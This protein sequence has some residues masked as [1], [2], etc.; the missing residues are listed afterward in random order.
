MNSPIAR[1]NL[2]F[3]FEDAEYIGSQGFC[4]PTNGVYNITVA[5]AA[6]GK[7]ICNKQ[8]AGY[9]FVRTVQVPLTR[10]QELRVVVGQRGTGACDVIPESDDIYCVLCRTPPRDSELCNVTW[11]NLTR[12]YDRAFYEVFGGG[13][14]GG[15][16]FVQARNKNTRVFNEFPFVIAGGGGGAAT[17]L[18]YNVVEDIEVQITV[19]GNVNSYRQFINGVSGTHSVNYG[20]LGT[21]G[22]RMTSTSN[23]IAGVG[24]GYRLFPSQQAIPRDGRSLD[25]DAIGG[26]DCGR[27]FIDFGRDIPYSGVYGGFGGGGGGCAGGGGGGGYTGG[28][29]LGIGANVP[30]EGG[31]SY[32]CDNDILV[33]N[34]LFLNDQR[35]DGFV[36]IVLANCGCVHRCL[37][38]LTTD[39]FQ[40]LCPYNTELAPDLSDCFSGIILHIIKLTL[41]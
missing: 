31:Y 17:I 29:I 37:V 2:L 5:A 3:E 7:G 10:E 38:N 13:A 11:Y 32:V 26:L 9:G 39:R 24:G 36:D 6:G 18:D 21:Q 41:M 8:S 15:A 1:Q 20:L 35:E 14:G 16:S 22:F 4:V 28:A 19:L 25:G 40:C 34:D 27:T 30:G 33:F 23:F 12:E